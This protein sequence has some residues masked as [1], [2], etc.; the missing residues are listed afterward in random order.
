MM[1]KENIGVLK[2]SDIHVLSCYALIPTKQEKSLHW[3]ITVLSAGWWD[4]CLCLG[5]VWVDI[6][7]SDIKLSSLKDLA[8]GNMNHERLKKSVI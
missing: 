5:I 8:S 3:L 7:A 4:N 1:Y 6:I 2:R